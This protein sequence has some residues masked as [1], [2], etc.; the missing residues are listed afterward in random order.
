MH[1]IKEY[2][3]LIKMSSADFVEAK[4]YMHVGSSR[5]RLKTTNMPSFKEIKKFSSELALELGWEI[6][7]EHEPSRVCLLSNNNT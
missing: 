7:N 3:E 5:E 2:S 6:I 4:A 1:N